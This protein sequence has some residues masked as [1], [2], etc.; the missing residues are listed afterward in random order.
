MV[1]NTK[2]RRDDISRRRLGEL[3][4]NMSVTTAKMEAAS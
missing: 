1:M 4:T 2:Q 3:A